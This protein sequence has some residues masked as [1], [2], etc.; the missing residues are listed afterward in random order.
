MHLRM[1]KENA[2]DVSRL[3]DQLICQPQLWDTIRHRTKHPQSPHREV[4]DIWVRYNPIE[5]YAEDMQAFNAEHVPE[6]YP[7]VAQLPEAMRIACELLAHI[8]G[9]PTTWDHLGAVLITKIPPGK[10]VYAHV[11]QGW[12]ARH[13]E[14]FA[15]TVKGDDE[16]AFFFENEYLI[17]HPGDLWWFDNA[18][19]HWVSN[20]S[21]E[22]RITLIV[23]I[24]RH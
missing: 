18:H 20:N 17:T 14:K 5:N 24:R 3:Q 7:V 1:L 4:S 15:V 22:D 8:T 10:Q 23:C 11:D 9:T 16:Q 6:W 2:F 21:A 12:H 13:F 19:P